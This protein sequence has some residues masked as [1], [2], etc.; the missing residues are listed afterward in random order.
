VTDLGLL[1]GG[2]AL[3]IACLPS[4]LSRKVELV[5]LLKSKRRLISF[6]V[7]LFVLPLLHSIPNC[8][9]AN[10]EPN[11]HKHFTR[12]YIEWSQK[13]DDTYR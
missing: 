10:K 13:H 9:F 3:G 2:F 11:E 4:V 7:V 8:A 6:F 1:G 5:A 12:A